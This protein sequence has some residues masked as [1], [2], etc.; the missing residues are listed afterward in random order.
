M[1]CHRRLIRGLYPLEQILAKPQLRTSCKHPLLIFLLCFAQ[2]LKR[3]LLCLAIEV[4]PLAILGN[5][6][7]LPESIFALE[8][9]SFSIF[10]VFFAIR[11]LNLLVP[12]HVEPATFA[13]IWEKCVQNDQI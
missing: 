4:E 2:L 5:K 1:F 10:A 6:A 11:H 9:R 12:A 7:R 8:E 13:M 3:F